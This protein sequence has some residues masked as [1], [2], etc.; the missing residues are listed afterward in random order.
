MGPDAVGFF[1]STCC[2]VIRKTTGSEVQ[3]GYCLAELEASPVLSTAIS[4][5]T[6]PC[7]NILD[8]FEALN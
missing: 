2:S 8:I 5:K 3:A 7:F 1:V 6:E 4:P